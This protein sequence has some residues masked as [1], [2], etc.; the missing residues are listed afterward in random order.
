MSLSQELEDDCENI[1]S[2]IIL[3]PN[4]YEDLNLASINS[5]DI[6]H[7]FL[8]VGRPGKLFLQ[9]NYTAFT[10]TNLGSIPSK[11]EKTL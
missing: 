2:K 7:H 6:Y 4:T 1:G 9:P 8:R 5:S 10:K 11:I 3:K